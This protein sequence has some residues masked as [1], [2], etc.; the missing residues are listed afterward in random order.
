[1]GL[2]NCQR[3]GEQLE[4][5]CDQYEQAIGIHDG[6]WNHGTSAAS[7]PIICSS[8]NTDPVSAPRS[9]VSTVIETLA[10][11]FGREANERLVDPSAARIKMFHPVTVTCHRIRQRNASK[12]PKVETTAPRLG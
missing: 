12:R 11:S 3:C 7:W 6:D 4:R 10:V 1:M 8:S 5:Y 9:K 2:R